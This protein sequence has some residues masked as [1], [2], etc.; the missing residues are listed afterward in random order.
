MLFIQQQVLELK[1]EHFLTDY[2]V[3]ALVIAILFGIIGPFSLFTGVP[4]YFFA[5]EVS[6]LHRYYV[7]F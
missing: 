5:S 7:A 3:F 4:A 1:P 6:Q 2:R